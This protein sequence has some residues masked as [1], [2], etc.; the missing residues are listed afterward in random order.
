MLARHPA[1]QLLLL[2]SL[3]VG[4]IPHCFAGA[5][6]RQRR[7]G[8]CYLWAPLTASLGYVNLAVQILR[9]RMIVL[10][11]S[12]TWRGVFIH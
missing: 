7:I 12:G 1:L 2:L 4:A 8:V 10:G 6:P 3:R 11:R 9:T 5:S